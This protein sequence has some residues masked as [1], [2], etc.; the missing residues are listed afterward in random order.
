MSEVCPPLTSHLSSQ[1]A[2][3]QKSGLFHYILLLMLNESGASQSSLKMTSFV[4]ATA[5][6]GERSFKMMLWF[7]N[8]LECLMEFTE[9]LLK[10]I[11]EKA[12]ILKLAKE[13]E[14]GHYL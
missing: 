1:S 11:T 5:S 7:D 6:L 10:I 2:Y 9:N 8:L 4:T 13:R 3:F 12:H 14:T